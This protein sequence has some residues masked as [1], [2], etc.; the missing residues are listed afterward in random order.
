MKTT[1]VFWQTCL[2]QA[3]WYARA[4]WYLALTFHMLFWPVACYWNWSCN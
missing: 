2:T 3:K 1:D 4:I